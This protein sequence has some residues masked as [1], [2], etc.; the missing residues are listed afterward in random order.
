[1]ET[2]SRY[3]VLSDLED[4]KKQ[5]I[6]QRDNLQ[7]ETEL[8]RQQLET[9]ERQKEDVIEH[10][11]RQE[12]NFSRERQ[13]LERQKIDSLKNADRAIQDKKKEIELYPEVLIRRK[14]TINEQIKS[15]D[16]AINRFTQMQT[17]S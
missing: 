16:E 3:E 13:D 11:K 12:E 1:M 17:K 5:L 10:F 6:E 15:V 9:I 2:K 14:S 4:R 7:D 8:K